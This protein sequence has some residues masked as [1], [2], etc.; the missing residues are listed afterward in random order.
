[1][2]Q[3]EK[4]EVNRTSDASG[5]T[6]EQYEFVLV[7]KNRGQTPATVR[8]IGIGR[9]IAPAPPHTPMYRFFEGPSIE[10][11]VNAGEEYA[12]RTIDNTAVTPDQRKQ[13][14]LGIMSQ[15]V[16]GEIQFSDDG[17]TTTECGFVASRGAGRNPAWRLRGP[18]EYIFARSHATKAG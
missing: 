12:F 15:W 18:Q 16:W 9:A 14:D 17:G 3:I 13:I 6:E 1:L 8:R 4:I 2:L 11:V 10:A 5:A 7:W